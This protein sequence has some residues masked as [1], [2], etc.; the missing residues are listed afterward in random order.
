MVWL[1]AIAVAGV[2]ATLALLW[3][4]G[5]RQDQHIELTEAIADE[6]ADQKGGDE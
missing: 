4:I 3:R 5:R 1:C 6:L 2:A